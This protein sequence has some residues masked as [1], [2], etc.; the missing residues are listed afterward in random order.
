[1]AHGVDPEARDGT[2]NATAAGWAEHF[3]HREVIQRLAQI[4]KR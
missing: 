4:P 1:L 3:G 2:F